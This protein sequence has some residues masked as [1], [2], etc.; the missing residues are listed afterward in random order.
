M[1][2]PT[3]DRTLF[4]W[5]RAG[6]GM[7]SASIRAALQCGQ[8]G[9]ACARPSGNVHCPGHD[10]QH[11]SLSVK[12]QD[13][14]VL[15]KCRVGCDQ[16]ALID[17]LRAR[18]LWESPVKGATSLQTRANQA[19]AKQSAVTPPPTPTS[20]GATAGLTL[21]QLAEAKRLPV[22]LLQSLGVSTVAYQGQRAVRIPYLDDAG[23]AIATRYRLALNGDARFRW[24][25]G[26]KVQ[27][28]GLGRLQLARDRGW[29]LLV[30]G[31]SDCWTS[32]HYEIPALG[33]PGKATW[34]ADWAVHVDGLD[35]YIWQEPGAED[36]SDRIGRDLPEARVIVAP[37]GT[38]DLSDA[39]T[40]GSD[41]PALV[42]KLRASS[43]PVAV[44]VRERRTTQVTVAAAAARGALE[45]TDVLERLEASARRLGYGGDTRAL[46]LTYLAVTGRV[47]AVPRGGILCHLLLLGPPSAG[48]NFT[49]RNVRAHLPEAAYH[50]IDAGSPRTLIYDDA[51]LQ[52]RVVI[53]G[54]ADSLPSGED[55]PAAS[56]IR[57]LL[58]DG[59]LHYSVT[60]RSETTGEYHVKEVRKPGPTVLVT[61][62]VK[63]LGEQLMTRLFAVEVPYDQAQVR[64][65]LLAQAAMDATGEP[66][67][68]DPE[69]VALQDYLQLGAPWP[70]VVPY[71]AWLA[72]RIAK[73]AQH[74][75]VN[76]DFGK[77][78]SL[79]RAHAV[80]HVRHRQMD[81]R[82]RI[83][84][85]PHDYRAVH[86]LVA[87]YYQASV[88]G[89]S[90]NVRTVVAAVGKLRETHERVRQADVSKTTGLSGMPVSRAVRT[91]IASGWL[92]NRALSHRSNQS[93][94][95]GV[96]EPLPDEQVLPDPAALETEAGCNPLTGLTAGSA[97]PL[98][99]AVSVGASES[100]E[101][102]E[103]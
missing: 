49:E 12:E 25:S 62:S 19:T 87:D 30:E 28:Y 97:Y 79:I 74:P 68:P 96:G 98:P 2:Y 64:A 21:E 76:R 27:P 75:R 55:N 38:K 53:F 80:L 48:K 89:A 22:D 4:E 59:E 47:L 32:W 63:S 11:P 36:F 24:K 57:N 46:K 85:T 73:A 50:V 33:V 61:T 102:G 60:V 43:V 31:E 67:K 10:D 1:D 40:E 20:G 71:A 39:H 5:R 103:L 101:Y 81:G 26:D 23:A 92:V 99:E 54:E 72:E 95:L 70:V 65:A 82:G 84:A 94:D 83:I 17:A 77:L 52:H 34:K 45:C 15:V 78:L 66:E 44:L 8:P 69:L 51:D 58:Q 42:E 41:V 35:V 29:V 86:A 100:E 90:Q 93:Y 9:C 7:D 18:G 37:D 14:K 56:A 13:G 6:V 91:A 3:S 88:T 16:D